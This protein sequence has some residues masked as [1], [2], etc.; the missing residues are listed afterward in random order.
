[1]N[2][3]IKC[4]L[5]AIGLSVSMP[6]YAIIEMVE[7]LVGWSSVKAASWLFD[8]YI[9]RENSF[10]GQYYNKFTLGLTMGL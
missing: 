2:K 6:S 1:M 9:V 7:L 8:Y 5:L 4:C 3:K 10:I